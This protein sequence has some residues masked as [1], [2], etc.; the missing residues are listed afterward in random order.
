MLD[1]KGI[2]LEVFECDG[3]DKARCAEA[4]ISGYPHLVSAPGCVNP[5]YLPFDNLMEFAMRN[6][7]SSK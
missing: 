2:A 7:S 5:G 6:D 3:K 4:G 1:Q